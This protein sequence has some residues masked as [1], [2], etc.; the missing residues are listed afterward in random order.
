MKAVH[1]SVCLFAL[2]LAACSGGGS[3]ESPPENPQNR[4]PTFVTPPIQISV[5]ENIN[6]P[7][8]SIEASDP[9]GDTLVF[10]IIGDDAEAFEFDSMTGSLSFASAPDFELPGDRNSDNVY[11]AALAARDTGGLSASLQITVTV[12][13]VVEDGDPVRYRDPVFTAL[14]VEDDVAFATVDGQTLKLTIYTP[15][16]DTVTDRPVMIVASGGG[17]LEQDRESV[18]PIAQDF[19]R[20]GYV[21]A[22][23]DY[24]VLGRQPFDADELAIAG[25]T[26]TQDMFAAVRFLRAEGEGENPRGI[27]PG[28]IFVSGESAGGVMAMLAATLDP[29]D[30]ISRPAL[31]NF[32][33]Q[34]GGV[35]GTVGDQNETSSL[36][37][38]AMPLSGAIFDVATV[39]LRSGLLYAAHEELDPIVPCGTDEERSSLTGLVVSGACDVVPAYDNVVQRAEL[40]LVR[41]AVRHVEFTED[42][43][44]EI[45]Q[46]A[47]E[48]FF[49]AGVNKSVPKIQT[50]APCNAE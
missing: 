35:Y 17:F 27:R 34:N 49:E 13:N 30:A 9:D 24:R 2:S 8:A 31:A 36:V 45:Y 12:T 28:A 11:E 37:Q 6:G 46:G 50:S 4:A 26:A 23:M 48:L 32:A 18:E 33:A 43:R 42:Q 41:D 47:A 10:S 5:E 25:L 22:T 3:I 16:C 44:R 15:Q 39:D 21:A 38:G 29:D 7:I 19:A 1:L 20:R 14:N 40:F